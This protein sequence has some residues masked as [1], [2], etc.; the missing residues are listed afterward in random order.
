MNVTNR[1]DGVML[2][3]LFLALELTTLSL[4]MGPTRPPTRQPTGLAL[5]LRLNEIREIIAVV[6]AFC[7]EV[8]G[9]SIA[10]NL[11]PRAVVDVV[12]ISKV[13]LDSNELLFCG[14]DVTKFCL[15]HNL[16]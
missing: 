5:Y 14:F 3:K 10:G 6:S 11:R 4:V 13:H 9:F 12:I 7:V 8:L 1:V 15:W 2:I 16:T